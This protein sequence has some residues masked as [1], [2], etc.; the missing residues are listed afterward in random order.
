MLGIKPQPNELK[1]PNPSNG[2]SS[3]TKEGGLLA[4]LNVE[5]DDET[6]TVLSNPIRSSKSEYYNGK[7]EKNS[8][9]GSPQPSVSSRKSKPHK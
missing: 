8:L 9:M 6:I 1:N 3:V 7:Y 2:E 4:Q 5:H